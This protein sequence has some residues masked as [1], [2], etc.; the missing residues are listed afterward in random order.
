MR[1]VA[2]KNTHAA[3]S[4]MPPG[5]GPGRLYPGHAPS[6]TGPGP[7]GPSA[8]RTM[9]CHTAQSPAD[10]RPAFP[11]SCQPHGHSAITAY[12]PA[13]PT[14]RAFR[15][16]LRPTARMAPAALSPGLALPVEWS[17]HPH[18]GP[19]T[20]HSGLTPLAITTSF[21]DEPTRSSKELVIF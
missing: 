2:R 11:R 19:A 9:A 21:S 4:A 13:L 3:R 14:A 15:P 6:G 17:G 16:A 1:P 18:G 12:R 7:T 10:L 8:A 20:P 5:I